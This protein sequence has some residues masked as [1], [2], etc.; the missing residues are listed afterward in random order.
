MWRF[1][2][3]DSMGRFDRTF[4]YKYTVVTVYHYPKI[5]EVKFVSYF[6]MLTT[7]VNVQKLT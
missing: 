5:Y 4:D 1:N 3:G 2:R 7:C 6:V